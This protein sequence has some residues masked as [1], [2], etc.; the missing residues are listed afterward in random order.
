MIYIVIKFN[1]LYTF[2]K[3]FRVFMMVLVKNSL[4]QEVDINMFLNLN[5]K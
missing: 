3:K 4:V 1:V 2:F 5:S